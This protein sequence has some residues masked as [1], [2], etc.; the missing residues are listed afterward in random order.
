MVYNLFSI[1]RKN[2]PQ[3]SVNCSLCGLG[4]DYSG[5]CDPCLSAVQ[6]Q[7]QY[8]QQCGNSLGKQP[9]GAVCGQCLKKPP[10]YQA[11]ISATHYEFP[12][13]HAISEMKFEKQLH[14]IRS[15]SNLLLNELIAYYQDIPLPQAIVPIPLHSNRLRERG[16]NQSQLIAK[17]LTRKLDIPLL[18][19]ALLRIKDTPHQIGLKAVERR[20]NL[21]RAFTVKQELPKHIALVD[22]VVTTGSTIQEASKQCLK[23]G[24]ERIDVWCLAK[25]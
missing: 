20:K 2:N 5:F 1:V 25:T 24:V 18:E 10:R 15:F 23:H 11:L 21:K 19:H 22:D 16:F 7:G 14:H 9:I 12:V 8:C 4:T 17:H 3:N 13:N 6:R